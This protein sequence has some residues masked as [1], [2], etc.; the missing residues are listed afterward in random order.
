MT[1][2]LQPTVLHEADVVVNGLGPV[3]L[4]ACILLGRRGYTVHGVERWHRQ[5]G[6]PRAVTFDHEIA[7]V[8]GLIGINSEDDPGIEHH[9][10]HYY[11][12]NQDYEVLL[13]PDWISFEA[14]GYHNRYWFNQPELEE[15]LLTIAQT[16]PNV[17]LHQGREAVAF[18]Q[19]ADGV[20]LT[21][22]EIVK[23]RFV[24]E[25]EPGGET[26]RIRAKYAIGSDGANSFVRNAVGAQLTD[27]GFLF[28]WLIVDTRPHEYPSYFTAHF[29]VCDPARPTTV[30]PG[31]PGRRRWEW[32]L[33]PGEDP[34]Q[35][36]SEENVWKLLEPWGIRPDNAELERAAV[37][38]F[39]AKYL[40]H[41]RVG[42]AVLVGDA[43][44]L[45]PPFAGEGMC[46]GLRDVV[47]LIWRL[48]LLLRGEAGTGLLDEWSHERRE[49]AKYYIDFSVELGKVIC[50]ADPAEAAERDARMKAEYAE[51]SKT[52]PLPTHDTV[53]GT[54]TW[55]ADDELAGVTSI[56]GRVAYQGRTGRFDDVVGR[57]QW[58]LL[59][60]PGAGDDLDP[61]RRR[62]LEELGGRA[63][64]VGPAGSGAEIV[65]VGGT[66]TDWFAAHGVRHLLV[67][68][69]FYVA[70]TAKDAAEL[71][72]RFDVIARSIRSGDTV[73]A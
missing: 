38:R 8:L 32:M 41:W 37:T 14:N 64:T 34:A 1:Q 73:L 16:L 36:G 23:D 60:A 68:P 43:A 49:Q 69:D 33:K 22:R 4:L 58:F 57:E 2:E 19:D 28:T 48:D 29:Q 27:L 10:D 31:G 30:V 18:E 54:G 6:R 15:R 11:W 17:H 47:N 63:L 51:Q 71:G 70:F 46:A 72:A 44:H 66:Y 21:Y 61:E 52:G 56:Q 42:R 50:I 45:M 62:R 67:R 3:G 13:E 53:L 24:V 7:R 59:S 9:G 65:D 12:V 35:F 25:F 55:I 5:Y 39:E 26:G 40:E 20:T